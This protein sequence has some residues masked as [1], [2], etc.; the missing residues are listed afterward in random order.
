MTPDPADL[1]LVWLHGTADWQQWRTRPPRDHRS[2]H[3]VWCA[4][5]VGKR[6]LLGG[7]YATP[8]GLL[9]YGLH[10]D[11]VTT[12]VDSAGR[13]VTEDTR[14]ARRVLLTETDM[15]TATPDDVLHLACRH[16]QADP[17]A[18]TELLSRVRRHAQPS[19]NPTRTSN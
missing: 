5:S 1:A 6:C 16:G 3:D 4:A 11:R 10:K 12:G 8:A 14:I 17:V 13:D 19:P 18:T 9:F 2:L 15:T 7:I